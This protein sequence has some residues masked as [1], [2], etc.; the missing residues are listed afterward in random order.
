[1]TQR[2]LRSVLRTNTALLALVFSATALLGAQQPV[3][4]ASAQA[5]AQS[6]A[7]VP[8]GGPPPRPPK[9]AEVVTGTGP[10]GA[11]MRCR[12]G[13]YPAPSAADNACETKGGILVRFALR[14]VPERARPM[15][16][17]AAPIV[18]P[19]PSQTEPDAS[20]RAAAPRTAASAIPA[21]ATFICVDGSVIVADTASVRCAGK[22]GVSVIFPQKRR[23]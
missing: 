2:T 6:S 19:P 20:L 15:P 11:K 22:G 23:P 3:A 8:S 21:N 1:M 12:D 10:N 18:P 4:P 9:P 5:S 13:S 17:V 7:V 16:R 14:R